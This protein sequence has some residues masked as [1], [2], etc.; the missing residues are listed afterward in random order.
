MPPLHHCPVALVGDLRSHAGRVRNRLARRRYR[1]ATRRLVRVRSAALNPTPAEG[2]GLVR[3]A[4]ECLPS[5]YVDA[6][7][8]A[9]G[10]RSR[11]RRTND[12]GGDAG[13]MPIHAHR[14]TKTGT[15]RDAKAA[16]KFLAPVVVDNCLADDA[17]QRR[18][19]RRQPRWHTAAVKGKVSTGALG[20]G[21]RSGTAREYHSSSRATV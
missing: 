6:K 20:H 4:R 10:A 8:P 13:G 19:A 14:T 18:H 15:R 7:P 17:T 2:G 1:P 21:S 3:R 11:F 9:M 16:Q 12:T 5:A